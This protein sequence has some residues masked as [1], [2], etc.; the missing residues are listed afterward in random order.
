MA[1]DDDRQ[2]IGSSV[3]EPAFSH[4]AA[5]DLQAIVA[6]RG[7]EGPRCVIPTASSDAL[8]AILGAIYVDAGYSIMGA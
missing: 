5:D 6:G 3:E 1:E 2:P 4:L 8:E 7:G